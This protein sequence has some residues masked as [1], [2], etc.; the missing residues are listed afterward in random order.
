MLQAL[1]I[2]LTVLDAITSV[3]ASVF[4]KFLNVF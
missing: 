2:S 3:F 1:V 4:N